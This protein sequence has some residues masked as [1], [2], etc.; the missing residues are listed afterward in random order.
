MHAKA[1]KGIKNPEGV[2]HYK[3]YPA[4]VTLPKALEM[5]KAAIPDLTEKEEQEVVSYFTEA[6]F[7]SWDELER[8]INRLTERRSSARK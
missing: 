3:G 1:S 8:M 6:T 5:I 2:V 4:G 7:M